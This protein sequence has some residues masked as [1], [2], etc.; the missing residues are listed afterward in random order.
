MM[1]VQG[2]QKQSHTELEYHKSHTVLH[3]LLTVLTQRMCCE[4]HGREEVRF[5]FTQDTCKVFT[6]V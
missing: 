5:A 6:E 3:Y 2:F 4:Q 1:S